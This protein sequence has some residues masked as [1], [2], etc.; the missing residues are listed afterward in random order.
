MNI[1]DYVGKR[2]LLNVKEGN[3]SSGDVNEFKILEVSPSGNWV[4]LLNLNGRKF[5]K[6]I[7]TISFVE[8]LRDFNAERVA[9]IGE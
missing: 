7:S 3:W 8:E 4:K 1:Q 2:C 5:W 6:S 9:E